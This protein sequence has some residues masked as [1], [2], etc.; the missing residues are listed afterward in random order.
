MP[1]AESAAQPLIPALPPRVQGR[2]HLRVFLTALHAF[3]LRELKQQFGRSRLGYFWA[4]AE[5]AATVAVLT[6]IHAGIRGGEAQIYGAHPIV[7]FVFGAVPFFTYFH[8]VNRCQNVCGSH[9]G[10]F[11]YRQIKPVDIMLARAIIEAL[12]MLTVGVLFVIGWLWL[13]H[14]FSLPDPL[15]LLAA[16][17]ALFALGL[18]VGLIFEVFG[19]VYPDLR[20]VFTIAMR[21]MIFISGLFFTIEMIPPQH[22]HLL[23]WNPVLH[24]VDFAREGVLAGY[25]SPA[26]G[27][28]LL[29]CILGLLLVAFSAYRRFMYRLI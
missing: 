19:T 12:S 18:A 7:F 25:D 15:V 29:L 27:S 8:C 22:R 17:L 14:D 28:Y 9:K 11:N 24:A 3:L 13:G 20:R 4:V 6:L 23:T 10:L 2:S 21:P 1:E 5:P 26:S 16:M